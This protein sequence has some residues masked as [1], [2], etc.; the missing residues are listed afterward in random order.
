MWGYEDMDWVG[1]LLVQARWAECS[2]SALDVFY[3][4]RGGSFTFLSAL[5][6]QFLISSNFT[7][8]GDF[9]EILTHN[10]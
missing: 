10:V 8:K 9:D 5:T 2:P 3:E 6:H 1:L 4:V 7:L